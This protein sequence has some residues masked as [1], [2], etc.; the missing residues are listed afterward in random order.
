MNKQEVERLIKQYR[1]DGFVFIDII[2]T[3]D[4]LVTMT[5]DY[6]VEFKDDKL[7]FSI[8]DE[9]HFIKYESIKSIGV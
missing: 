9:R 7:I 4:K 8:D 2:T 6:E 5:D 3:K 1:S